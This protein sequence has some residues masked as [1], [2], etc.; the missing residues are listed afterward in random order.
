MK[1]IINKLFS[2]KV[3][4][5]ILILL[6]IACVAGSIITQGYSQ[7]YY[8][9]FYSEK[10]VHLIMALGLNDV[11]HTWWF[12]TLT[13]FL[14]ISLIG[15]NLIRYKP[16]VNKMKSYNKENFIKNDLVLTVDY[17]PSLLFKKLGFNKTEQKEDY[18]YASKNLIGLWGAW[19]THLGIFV[20]IIGFALGQITTIKY[21]VYGCVGDELPVEDT[22]LILKIN[23]F[24]IN[25]RDDETVEQYISN[26]T[27]INN[28]TGVAETGETSVNH[29]ASL[30]GYKIY[31]NSTG[32][33]AK[34][35]FI[36]NDQLLESTR[37]CAG[38]YVSVAS[39]PGLDILFNAFYPDYI[40]IDG[41][42]ATLSS[43]LVNPGYLYTVYYNNN[44]IGMNVLNGDYIS[45]EG[46]N[47]EDFKI[48]FTDPES[49]SLLQLK[50]DN[51]VGVVFGGSVI[52]L[53]ALFI[54]FYMPTKEMYAEKENDKWNIYVKSRKG[55]VL[56]KDQIILEDQNVRKEKS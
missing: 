7:N 56:L 51:S 26:I 35:N 22:N 28:S 4:I 42:P 14:C 9:N 20:I 55:N 8:L 45:L 15:C 25:L 50:K 31:Q 2:M 10:T 12:V 11:F 29:P 44:L 30:H 32:W 52:L 34:V 24:N 3:A 43:Q 13:I 16:I 23:S 21:T 39:L 19:L 5:A 27:V 36:E 48:T 40:Q 37:L 47:G 33:A 46:P 6:I 38:E 17:N 1:K 49:Y 18:I 41:K 53:I 54:A